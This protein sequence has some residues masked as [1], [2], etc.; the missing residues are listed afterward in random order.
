[1]MFLAGSPLNDSFP[2]CT[3]LTQPLTPFVIMCSQHLVKTTHIKIKASEG[4][5]DI[6]FTKVNMTVNH[7][8]FEQLHVFL[9]CSNFDICNNCS[10]CL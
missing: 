3:F 9:Y 1:M 5:N 10:A 6:H 4:K 2:K 7:R 8:V